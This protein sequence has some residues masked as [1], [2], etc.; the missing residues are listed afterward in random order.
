M[1]PLERK[2]LEGVRVLTERHGVPPSYEE[3]CAYIGLKSRSGVARM[4]D[5]L[6]RQGVL[7][8]EPRRTRSLRIVGE[9]DGLRRMSSR[10]LRALRLTITDILLDRGD[11]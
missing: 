10:D 7:Q 8:R 5:S 2:T 3:L 4:V 6:E 1:T 11:G 9:L